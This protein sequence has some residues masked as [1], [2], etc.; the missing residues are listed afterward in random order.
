[1]AN[2]P[3]LVIGSVLYHWEHGAEYPP[4]SAPGTASSGAVPVP[5][6]LEVRRRRSA[7][8]LPETTR[9]GYHSVLILVLAERHSERCRWAWGR[10]LGAGQVASRRSA[11]AAL[12]DYAFALLAVVVIVAVYTKLRL[13]ALFHC[14]WQ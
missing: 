6:H 2:G 1:M 13:P 12:A 5:A 14:S 4:V 10:L 8:L 11:F 3:S 9:P 7:A